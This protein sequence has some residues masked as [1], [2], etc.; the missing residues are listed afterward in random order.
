MFQ[1]V[2]L[3]FSSVLLEPINITKRFEALFFV[4]NKDGC[5]VIKPPYRTAC[6]ACDTKISTY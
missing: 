6:Y 2:K 4:F 1:L 3:F 5:A